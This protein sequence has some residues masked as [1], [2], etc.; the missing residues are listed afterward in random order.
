MKSPC[1]KKNLRSNYSQ[2]SFVSFC[3]SGLGSCL[4]IITPDQKHI[5]RKYNIKETPAVS[6]IRKEPIQ[7]TVNPI[8]ISQENYLMHT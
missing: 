5:P 7:E 2:G 6:I 3:F 4:A 1:L 8:K